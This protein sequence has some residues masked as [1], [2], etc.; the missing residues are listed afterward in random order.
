M[1]S[2]TPATPAKPAAPAASATVEGRVRLARN[3]TRARCKPSRVFCR[4]TA[5]LASAAAIASRVGARFMRRSTLAERIACQLPARRGKRRPRLKPTHTRISTTPATRLRMA[6]RMTATTGSKPR[7]TAHIASAAINPSQ[8]VMMHTAATTLMRPSEQSE[9]RTPR[10]ERHQ[11]EEIRER[12]ACR[13]Q[14]TRHLAEHTGGPRRRLGAKAG[15]I[16]R[17]GAPRRAMRPPPA[18]HRPNAAVASRRSRRYLG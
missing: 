15:I 9:A 2:H 13:I 7:E 17:G 4:D 16:R 10:L 3:A 5:S 1:R 18:G 8:V 14:H 6:T 12:F 11:L